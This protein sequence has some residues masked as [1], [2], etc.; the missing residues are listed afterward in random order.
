MGSTRLLV[1]FEFYI[2]VLGVGRGSIGLVALWRFKMLDSQPEK[3]NSI[4]FSI[5]FNDSRSFSEKL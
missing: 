3:S 1:N 4:Q 5:D 2:T